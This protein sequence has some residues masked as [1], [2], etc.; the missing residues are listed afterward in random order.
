MEFEFK[1]KAMPARLNR[2]VSESCV[3]LS[4][5]YVLI[6][7][8]TAGD[9]DI[10]KSNMNTKE[11]GEMECV[12][13][14]RYLNLPVR[15][16]EKKVRMQLTIGGETVRIS[17]IELSDNPSFW[18]FMD[19]SEFEGKTAT[20]GFDGLPHTSKAVELI[21]QSDEIKGAQ[22]LYN[23]SL[24][25]QFH[26]SQKRGWNN[27]PNGMVYYEGEWHLYYQHNP[28]GWNWDNMHWGHAVSKDLVHWD[29][30][31][32]ALYPW[33][34]AR[35]HCF[36]GSAVIDWNN[37]AGFQE[38][39]ERVLVAAF[40][41]TGCGESIAFSNDKGRTFTYYEGNP[42]VKHAGR[43]PKIV[44]FAPGEHWVMAVYDEEG[45]RG[46]AFYSST[47]LKN[48]K[49]ESKLN[50]YFECPE[51][52]KIPVDG[53]AKNTR[54]VVFAADA[55]YAIG[56]FDGKRFTPEDEGKHQLHWGSYYAS[57]TFSHAP[58]HD[59][60]VA[61]GEAVESNRRRIQI[62]W[63][64]INMA[65]MPFNQTF[66]FPTELTLRSTADG[67]RM[68]GEPVAEIENLRKKTHQRKPAT[69]TDTD[70]CD[71]ATAG[72]LLEIMAEFSVG[73]AV[74]F[75]V[76]I[77]GTKVEY[78]MFR[79]QLMGMPLAPEDGRIRMR[80][81]VDRPM[82]EVFGNGG[83]VIMTSPFRS[84]GNIESISAFSNGG[85]TKLVNLEVHELESI[86]R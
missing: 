1:Q 7:I 79:K 16:G 11:Y 41:D 5:T 81:L 66:S 76:D 32:I 31:P 82:I 10:L 61:D 34:M 22:D 27:D 21:E 74:S 3:A 33:S 85:S 48:W 46:I 20:I 24:R 2:L 29:E 59:G 19:V 4:I 45:G 80:I 69:L 25:P 51:I 77:G 83:R 60:Q 13:S 14:K 35:E 75:G 12:V 50:G 86:W 36:S 52:F 73:D 49:R 26:F 39:D 54:W 43:D 17:N 84:D 56:E 28:Y 44:W 63:A 23:E 30:M 72:D 15:A 68:F 62:G 78:D 47:D 8:T 64:R 57:Q 37:S 18:V 55:Q 58:D 9:E 70:H 71:L 38:G 40:T 65:D 6:A 67:I 53:D 42:V